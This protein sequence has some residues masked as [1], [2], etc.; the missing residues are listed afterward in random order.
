MNELKFTRRRCTIATITAL[1][2]GLTVC[3]QA[4]AQATTYRISDLGAFSTAAAINDVGQV[5]GTVTTGGT[6]RPFVWSE[7][8][9][10]TLLGAVGSFGQANA[11]NNAGQVVGHS[12]SAGA[13]TQGF[14]W[15]EDTGMQTLF[16][17]TDGE[18]TATSINNSG[19]VVGYQRDSTGVRLVPLAWSQAKATVALGLSGAANGQAVA[20]DDK[21]R[22]AG[23]LM[24]ADGS[25]Y[26]GGSAVWANVGADPT[27]G[28]SA[29]YNAMNTTSIV[30]TVSFEF[31]P[32]LRAARFSACATGTCL[33]GELTTMLGDLPGEWLAP[34]G[35]PRGSRPLDINEAGA[36]VG[37]SDVPGREHAFI[38]TAEAGIVDLNTLVD[39]NDPLRASFELTLARGINEQ[40]WIV[41]NAMVSGI[42]HAVLLT[43]VPEP[44]SAVLWLLGAI[45][46]ACS[47]SA[48]R[49][50]R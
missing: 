43:P 31:G 21:G 1:L 27:S 18:S 4:H 48:R 11:I 46:C 13:P 23:A 50:K 41:G 6:Q 29:S 3:V 17:V 12:A 49:R 42:T 5:V 8:S 19:I 40:G 38:W 37:G 26:L 28:G 16:A 10:M 15:T 34:N 20:I 7:A 33:P 9:G 36:I 24:G 22:I 25:A 39:A 45:T 44:T 32:L 35:R 14:L 2:A 30:G 47:V